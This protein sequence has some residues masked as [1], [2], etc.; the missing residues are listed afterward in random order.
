MQGETAVHGLKRKCAI[1]KKS[2]KLNPALPTKESIWRQK[3]C[4]P[5]IVCSA[6]LG[7]FHHWSGQKEIAETWKWSE[8][9]LRK[10]ILKTL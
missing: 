2:I 9:I 6:S 8:R 10:H 5:E 7:N 3:E 4:S 1:V